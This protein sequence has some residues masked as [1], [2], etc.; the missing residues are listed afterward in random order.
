[1]SAQHAE[2]EVPEATHAAEAS[3]STSSS[4]AAPA[5]APLS[6]SAPAPSNLPII[7]LDMEFD[8]DEYSDE[9]FGDEM[10]EN[11]MAAA[12]LSRSQEKVVNM[13]VTSGKPNVQ[14]VQSGG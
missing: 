7:P 11:E 1:M 2:P 14:S 6:S 8:D 13:N 9:E 10:F 3:T 5:N 4:A 12:A